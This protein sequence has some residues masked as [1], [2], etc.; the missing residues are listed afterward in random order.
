MRTILSCVCGILFL[1]GPF[2]CVICLIFDCLEVAFISGILSTIGFWG[3]I[4]IGSSEVR[5][6]KGNGHYPLYN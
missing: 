1:F 5:N 6:A 4:Y 2:V 3:F